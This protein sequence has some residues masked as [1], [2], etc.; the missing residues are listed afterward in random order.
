M[1]DQQPDLGVQAITTLL[2]VLG[3]LKPETRVN[4]LDYVFKTLGITPIT[5]PAPAIPATPPGFVPPITPTTPSAF[6]SAPGAP[7][8]LR[9]LTQQKQ[10]K[11]DNQMVAVLA[12]YLANH[13]PQDQRR[14]H[15]V[16]EDIKRFFPQANFEL[17]TGRHSMTLINAKNAGYLDAL[18]DGQYRLNPVGHNLVTHKLPRTEG[19]S[20]LSRGRKSVKKKI[21]KKKKVK[22]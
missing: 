18:S 13:A 20:S 12:Y 11:S 7:T 1:A 5:P 10:P 22:G 15:I 3:P 16:A 19:S 6:S 8:D 17:P 21:V 2:E 9:S 4:V 14:D